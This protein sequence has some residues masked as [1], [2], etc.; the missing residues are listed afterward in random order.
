MQE[1]GSES[2]LLLRRFE[3]MGLEVRRMKTGRC[4]L[5]SLRLRGGSLPGLDHPLAIERVV[6]SLVGRDRI[7]CLRPRSLFVLPLLRVLDCPNPA[8]LE[9][10]IREA[11]SR[12][13][14]ELRRA[15]GWLASL[16][17]EATGEHDGAVLSLPIEG[18]RETVRARMIDAERVILPGTG[19]LSK[20]RLAR[21]EDRCFRIDRGSVGSGIDVSIALS[22]RLE[23]LCRVDAHRAEERRR[24]AL[25]ET[26]PIT[27]T[28]PARRS[29]RILL[30]GPRIARERACI[31]SFRLRGYEVFTARTDAEG[32][33]SFDGSSPELVLADARL[34]RAEGVELVLALQQLAGVEEIPVV[35][36]DEQIRTDRRDAARSVGAAGYLVHPIDVSRIA[37]RLAHMVDRPRRR[38]FTRYPRRLA[39]RI[40]GA[41]TPS[42]VTALGRGGMFLATEQHLPARSIHR[43]EV[44]LPEIGK[45]LGVD[46]EVLYRQGGLTTEGAGIGARFHAFPE[47]ADESVLIRYLRSLEPATP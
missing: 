22:N 35:L 24:V 17:V 41:S 1:A 43:V 12:H 30:V 45:R 9:H 44:S 21:A 27:T 36:V 42:L 31:E 10:R 38:R 13:V 16:G 6:F 4:A 33:A 46:A 2:D 8:A 39:A 32:L 15:R 5:A 47:R 23:E 25:R 29:R 34:G 11:W 37:E 18:E 28:S 14:T 20:R 26:P 19:P 3:A 7:K 40:D